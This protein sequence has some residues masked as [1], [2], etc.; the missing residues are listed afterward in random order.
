[1]SARKDLRR[2]GRQSCRQ[3]V[4]LRW[5]DAQGNDKYANVVALDVSEFGLSLQTRE[6]LP[7]RSRVQ[8]RAAKLGI[9]G[10]ATVRRC[11]QIGTQYV[12]GVEFGGS[13]RWKP[14]CT[15]DEIVLGTGTK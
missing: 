4:A 1:M 15:I 8:L 11:A 12:I 2:Q 13:M 5:S 7:L 14:P 9:Q 10:E 6:A 3:P